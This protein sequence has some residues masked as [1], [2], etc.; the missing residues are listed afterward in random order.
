[1]IIASRSD[2]GG[3]GKGG[4]LGLSVE[5]VI[6]GTIILSIALT[7]LL[8]VWAGLLSCK[9]CFREADVRD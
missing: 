9:V 7:P 6:M 4:R 3:K 5:Q 1:M 2:V 8:V